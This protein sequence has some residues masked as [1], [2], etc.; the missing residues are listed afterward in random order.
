M[1]TFQEYIIEQTMTAQDAEHL[2]G[3]HGGYT[4]NELKSAYKRMAIQH[5]PDKGG[6]VAYMQRIN[7]AYDKLSNMLSGGR[8]S[9]EDRLAAWKKSME[10]DRVFLVAALG[11][12]RQKLNIHALTTHFKAIFDEDFSVQEKDAVDSNYS[13]ISVE[14]SNHTRTTVLDLHVHITSSQRH[15]KGLGAADHDINMYVSTSILHN[16]RKIKLSQQNYR[17]E[18]DSTILSKPDMLFPSKKLLVKKTNKTTKFSRKDALLSLQKEI[19]ATFRDNWLT[20]PLPS[21]E[22]MSIVF[23]RTVFMRFAS[24]GINGIY[25]KSRRYLEV[26]GHVSFQE[27]E[28]SISWLIERLKVIQK[29]SDPVEIQ[30][31]LEHMM[32]EYK[33]HRTEI[34]PFNR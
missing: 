22:H 33:T 4:A 21:T 13:S 15:N 7:A 1:K 3:L 16:R 32:E 20:I 11:K 24:W 26:K 5:H 27:T 12:V 14:F 9:P 17:F 25:H 34:D 29:L 10:Q 28:A 31:R 19:H 2:L 30:L 23:Y 8:E 18:H 6:D